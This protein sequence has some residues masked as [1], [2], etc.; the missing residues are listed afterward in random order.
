MIPAPSTLQTRAVRGVASKSGFALAA[1]TIA[2]LLAPEVRTAAAA[3]A[4]ATATRVVR[5][6][7]PPD[8]AAV[9]KLLDGVLNATCPLPGVASGGQ[10]GAGQVKALAGAGFR[11]VLDLRA[12]DEPRGYDEAGAVKRAGLAY[13]LLPVTAATLGDAT[14]DRVRA[15]MG[16]TKRHP[17]MV[18][19]ASGN[20]VGVVLLP[21]L[22]LDRGWSLKDAVAMAEQGGMRTGPLRE[23]ALD[24]I[25][26]GRTKH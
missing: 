3:P 1:L 15:L 2:L 5:R 19:C 10:V 11:T 18:H 16:D 6:T 26:R 25:E 21:W 23:R 7:T 13:V 24:Y 17:V 4:P 22:V 12:P 20:R 14:F 9:M 8:S